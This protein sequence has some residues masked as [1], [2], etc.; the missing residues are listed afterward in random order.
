[1]KFALCNE[2]VRELPFERQCALAAGLGYEGLELAPFT[3]GENA[4]RMPPAERARLRRTAAGHGLSISGLHWLLV[5]PPGLSIT[6]ADADARRRTI[7]VMRGL[8]G[9][10]HDLGGAYLVHGSPG[11]RKTGGDPDA[12]RRGRE[13]FVSIAA[14][15]AAAGVTYCI[16]PLSADQ[17]DFVNTVAEAIE[18]VNANAN[19]AVRTMID[20]CSSACAER[21]TFEGLIRRWL[22]G[23][24]IAHIHFNDRNR[25]GP[26]QGSD[27]F[28]PALAALRDNGYSGWIGVEPFEYSPDGPTTAAQCI[29]YLKGLMEA[30]QA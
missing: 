25:R 7:D 9:L 14:D 11:Q 6:S 24:S 29:G 20:A 17:T 10:C 23:G 13:A 28:G 21:E 16:E 22:P 26:G 19:L 12:H 5:D 27:R 3:L 4:W 1:M 18:I 2:V 8:I 30:G 15:A